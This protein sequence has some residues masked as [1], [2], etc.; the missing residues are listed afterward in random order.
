M[1]ISQNE[2]TQVLKITSGILNAAPGATLL[3]AMSDALAGGTTMSQLASALGTYAKSTVLAG[4]VTADAQTQVLMSNLNLTYAATPVTTTFDGLVQSYLSAGITAGSN[5]GSLVY[6]VVSI[7]NDSALVSANSATYAGMA[8]AATALNNKAAVSNYYSVTLATPSGTLASLQSVLSSVT[9]TTPVATATDL[10][11]AAGV[12]SGM[13]F[14]ITGTGTAAA[15]EVMRL[16]G[17]QDVRI[18]FTNP[19]NQIKG[20]DLNGNGTIDNNGVEN[21]ITGKAALFEIVDAYARAPLNETNR[22]SNFLGDIAY[23]GTGFGGDGVT[24]DGNVVLGGL[25]GDTI[26]GGIGN[27][28]ITGGGVAASRAA[29]VVD[30]LSGGRNAD[31]FFVEMSALDNT[32]GNRVSIDGG[33]TADDNAAGTTQSAQDADWLLFEGSD[34][35]EPVTITLRDDTLLDVGEV[36]ATTPGTI[37]S[38]SG[39]TV[40]NLQDVENF[41]ASG[42]LYGFLDTVNVEIGGRRMDTREVQNGT[43]NNGIGSSAQLV[44]SGSNVANII[45]GGY[46]NDDISGNDGADLLMGGNLNNLINPN[47]LTI[48]NDGRD[49][50]T[51]GSGGDN[52]VF[53]ADGGRIEGDIGFNAIDAGAAQG[54]DTL[55]LTNKALGTG[56]AASMTTDG[57]LRFDLDAQS[58]DAA[59]GYGG[60]DSGSHDGV[61]NDTQDQTNYATGVARTTVQDIENLIATGLGAVDYD[62]DG[63]NTG[64]VGHL[65]QVNLLAYAGNLT[66]RGTD[67]G[68]NTLYASNGVDT[69]EGRGGNDLLSGGNGIDTFVFGTMNGTGATAQAAYG[70][71]IDVIHRQ[72]DANNDNIW[73]TGFVQ[74]FGMDSVSSQSA[75]ALRLTLNVSAADTASNPLVAN[76]VRE[77]DITV[78]GTA[79]VLT[80]AGMSAAT[81]MAALLTEVQ[82]ALTAHADAN[83]TAT[84]SNNTIS[85]V[86]ASGRVLGGAGY[87]VAQNSGGS[88]QNTVSFEPTIISTAM[89]VLLYKAYEDRLDNEAVN[90]ST[91][92]GSSISLGVD[93]YA[94][95][96]VISF[97]ADGTRIAEDQSYTLTFAN[98]TTQDVVTITVNGVQYQLTV[99]VDLDGNPIAAEDINTGGATT[100]ASIQTAFL[101]RMGA[102]A[103]GFINTFMDT[104]TVAGSVAST[105][106]A[107]TLVLTQNVYGSSPEQTVFMQ[108]PVVTLGNQSGGQPATITVANNAQH[109]V[110]LFNF[111]GRNNLLNTNNVKFIGDTGVTQAAL[112][113]ALTAGQT[114]IGNEALV[115]DSGANDLAATVTNTPVTAITAAAATVADNT[116]TNPQLMG[117]NF[118]VHGDDLLLGGAGNDTIYGRTGDDRIIGSTGTDTLDGGKN[119]YSVQIQAEATARV[120][121]MNA[122]ESASPAARVTAL[123]GLVVTNTAQVLQTESGAATVAAWDGT[124]AFDDT[125]QFQQVDVGASARFKVTLNDYTVTTTGAGAA[126]ITT[127][128]L[129]HGGAGTVAIDVAGD[130]AWDVGQVTTFTNFENIRTVSGT[131]LATAGHG[132]GF[133]TLDV[134][135]LSAS[136]GGVRYELSNNATAGEVRYDTAAAAVAAT[137]AQVAGNF[138]TN[139][140][141]LLIA[142]DGVENVIGG[143]GKDYLIIDETEA[144]KN[145]SF[146]GGTGVDVIDYQNDYANGAAPLTAP[147]L[148]AG[149]AGVTERAAQPTLTIKVNSAANVDTVTMTNGRVG[150][151][152]ATDTPTDT[153]TGVEVIQLNLNTARGG[154][155]ADT[156]DVRSM[157]AGAVVDYTNGQIRTAGSTPGNGVELTIV[158][159]A[160]IE[161]VIADGDDTVIVAS[162]GIMGANATSDVAGAVVGNDLAFATFLDYDELTT[163][164][165]L[166]RVA[167]TSLTTGAATGAT[168]MENWV[169]QSQFRFD[170]GTI[171]S[172][173]VDYSM[174]TD[175]ISVRVELDSTL[176]T[177]NVM[178]DS[179][180]GLFAGGLLATDRVDLLTSIEKIVAAQ[181]ES[182]LDLT[183]STKGL[184]VSYGAYAAANYVAAYDRDVYNVQISDI[185]SS[186]PLTRTY[187]EHREAGLIATS[188]SVPAITT[189]TWSRVEG[190][191]FAERVILNSAHSLDATNQFNLRGGANEVKY[192]ELTKSISLTLAATDWVAG[193]N[194][195]GVITGTVTFQDGTGNQ[196]VGAALAGS[197][198]HTITSYTAQNAISLGSSLK[199]AA[200]QDAE[201][202]LTLA[203]TSDTLYLI[204]Q[205]GT[206]DNQ[207]TVS[208][209]SAAAKTSVVLTGFEL[210]ADGTSNDAY[211][212]G[213]LAT[214]V[215]GL[216]LTDNAG[217]DHDAIIVPATAGTTG[218]N[219]SPAGTISLLTLNTTRALGGFGMD[220]DILDITKV[221]ATGLTAIGTA[222]LDA[223]VATD[224]LV[225]GTLSK[226]TTITAFESLV[227]TEASAAGGAVVLNTTLNTV[228]QGSTTVTADVSLRALSA[229]GLVFEG[230]MGN[231][232][233]ASATSAVNL[234]ATGAGAVTLV[235]G[236][237]A[238]TLTG[239]AG[240]DT[241]AGGAGNDTIAGGAAQNN[242]VWSVTLNPN[243]ATFAGDT[244]TA[245]GRIATIAV[246]NDDV[247]TLG[248]QFA[249]MAAN[250]FNDGS[251]NNATAVS[252][253]AGTNTLSVTFGVDVGA[254]GTATVTAADA[255][256]S[257]LAVRIIVTNP[258][259]TTAFSLAGAGADVM[260]GGAGTDT[261]DGGAGNDTFV[262]VGAVDAAQAALYVADATLDTQAEVDAIVGGAAGLVNMVNDLQTAHATDVSG[263]EVIAGGTGANTIHV[264]GN[265]DL[266]GTTISAV[267]GTMAI[268][269]HSSLT[270][271]LAQLAAMSSITF[272][273][274]DNHTLVITNNDGTSRTAAQQEAD[275]IASTCPILV[276][277]AQ[278]GGVSPTLFTL[279]TLANATAAT[280]TTI[281]GVNAAVVAGITTVSP[282]TAA[283]FAALNNGQIA[284]S[285]VLAFDIEPE[286]AAS[287]SQAAALAMGTAGWTST[288][289]LDIVTVADVLID[290]PAE[291]AALA[292]LA[293]VDRI[294][295]TAAG[296]LSL[297]GVQLLGLNP[298]ATPKLQ[299]TGIINVTSATG[300]DM[301]GTT[302]VGAGGNDT[303]T[304]TSAIGATAIPATLTGFAS[305]TISALG[306]ATAITG[307]NSTT[308]SIAAGG[309]AADGTAI[310]VAGSANTTMTGLLGDVTSTLTGTLAVTTAVQPLLQGPSI[311]SATA[312]TVNAAASADG[313]VVTLGGTGGFT[314]TGLLGDVFSTTTGTVAVTTGAHA[315]GAGS[316]ITSATATSVNAAA[317]ADASTLAL[318]GTGAMTVTGLIGDLTST[319]TGVLNVTT[320][321]VAT[322]TANINENTAVA[323]TINANALTDGQVL[324]LA[325][326]TTAPVTV[327]LVAGDLMST[328]VSATANVTVTAT[329]G[330]NVI[331]TGAGADIINAGAGADTITGGAGIDAIDVG[332]ADAAIDTVII[333]SALA[334]NADT[335]ANFTVA[336]DILQFSIGGITLNAADYAAGATTAV[337]VAAATALVAVGAWNNH[338]IVD[339]AAAILAAAATGASSAGPA[340]TGGVLAIAT[341]TGAIYYDA[342]GN[343]TA[344]A[345]IIGAVTGGGSFTAAN[346][347][348]I[349]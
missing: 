346:L 204:A 270:L 32:D 169:N 108:T 186:V 152:G 340:A 341:D 234:S 67:A 194:A 34:D 239:A 295:I 301:V 109:E 7:L 218:F 201:D 56:T 179:T 124:N 76:D 44:V 300:N 2:L 51:G 230:E 323:K 232:Y 197:G 318:A 47:L 290:T 309:L 154:Y 292:A 276:T 113:T 293:I 160:Q 69:L 95:D 20:L 52:I 225:A 72:A 327:N 125:L 24:T 208:L 5:V 229:G 90:D 58:L 221:T 223:G 74:D 123:A 138:A 332:A 19:A 15:N 150:A 127:V 176:A 264:F 141:E 268:V 310:S 189:A 14:T 277:G 344:G 142:V 101:A 313:N 13:T 312:T 42:N 245:F 130:G 140:A 174:S 262:V 263:A 255:T 151:T 105:A 328:F 29:A 258:I 4:Q 99:G 339:T 183:Q 316:T 62:T 334:L 182:I 46:D 59:A 184:E 199:I 259:E 158:N 345:V 235:G 120:V 285:G 171:G 347:V 303:L 37:V 282:I 305:T 211:D 149:A 96:R 226:I 107:T 92:N 89:D 336:N 111:D 159:I 224:E 78:A 55:W 23:D 281:T 317:Q 244:V 119:W 196:A 288:D 61:A 250:T 325:G 68:A 6:T 299:G 217:A 121:E 216:I 222:T 86:D 31:F 87:V 27:D 173:T 126:A 91:T 129:T 219:G 187:V 212:M 30:T 205:T 167:Y 166:A 60:A 35:N 233:V 132:Q 272:A 83:L 280:V 206:T 326:S 172:D 269:S 21:A 188:A 115:I 247:D 314:V 134:S 16:T 133:D 148:I 242:N 64:D 73:D 93:S 117:A 170:L 40:G 177:Q 319:A 311:T 43:L 297:T 168:F 236:A 112:V 157:T 315:A 85:I 122:W 57:V 135:A 251:G 94:Q 228:T 22:S 139:A 118:A 45:V 161:R 10:G 1:A 146:D 215:A 349:G 200:S 145:N 289:A 308:A 39:Q 12:V 3:T 131:G 18:D 220:F 274:E 342:N 337:N 147:M 82:S 322:I 88:M 253:S 331:T 137:A 330:S 296:L 238:D 257:T 304:I 66:L 185:S 343:F 17:D 267:G 198:T 195:S 136:T 65:S 103:T 324:T 38:R 213:V 144:G 210:L 256:E 84:L 240:A 155:E 237:G 98:L 193:N 298:T 191:D 156:L 294:D 25:G 175:A 320:G 279:G 348:I 286:D 209:G 70:D 203:T 287:I 335:I 207:I 164:G 100:Q 261:M 33:T 271:T 26:F 214:A 266:T 41:D 8:S 75:S 249:A 190:S 273:G 81:T 178:V 102:P 338:V 180:G 202:S 284:L 302:F 306:G 246:A 275:L 110:L 252:Y 36:V 54:N 28:F 77:I 321:A 114:L 128:N 49:N 97:Q 9:A 163:T 265:A 278:V 333:N 48:T 50:L 71:N 162:S 291:A 116:N 143:T 63:T 165:T 11:I 231:S 241:L 227:L 79:V 153:L 283:A 260:R 307:L 53:E 80:T 192:N 181:G 254:T 106:T 104:N 243:A 329:T 248:T